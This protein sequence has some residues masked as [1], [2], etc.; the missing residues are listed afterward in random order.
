MKYLILLILLNSCI[1]EITPD[2]IIDNSIPDEYNY[3]SY[4]TYSNNTYYEK[5][6]KHPARN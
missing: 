4:N 5:I 2:E 1:S 3:K 6:E